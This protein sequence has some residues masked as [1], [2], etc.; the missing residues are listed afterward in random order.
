MYNTIGEGLDTI[1]D[2]TLGVGGDRLEVRD[3]LSGFTAG[4]S[5][6]DAYVRLSGGADTTVSVN[7]DGT[8]NDFVALATL[9]NVA[10]TNNLLNEMLANGNLLM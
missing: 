2:F 6:V 1:T 5:V 10:M 3:V 4:N 8:G 7:A 9:Q